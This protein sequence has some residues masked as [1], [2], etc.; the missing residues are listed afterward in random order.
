[1][2]APLLLATPLAAQPPASDSARLVVM[3]D[4]APVGTEDFAFRSGNGEDAIRFVA[5]T[6]GGTDPLRVAVT[7]TPRRLTMRVA[8]GTGEVAREYPGGPR[9]VVADERVLS[10]YALLALVQPGPVIVHGPPPGGRR[11]GTLEDGGTAPMP[12][13]GPPARRLTLRSGEDIVR[14]WLDGGGRLLRVE[15]PSRGLSA[16]RV[17]RP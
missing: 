7:T 8:S 14:V 13:G 17:I 12:N 15:I 9:S 2:I 1:M 5:T 3:K 4:G 11:D 16:E 10:L 6:T